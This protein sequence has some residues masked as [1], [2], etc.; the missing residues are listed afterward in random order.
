MLAPVGPPAV[1]PDAS[2]ELERLGEAHLLAGVREG[3]GVVGPLVVPARTACLHCQHL[4]RQAANPVWPL[5]AMQLVRPRDAGHDPCDV[6]LAS[7]VAALAVMQALD[8]LDHAGGPTGEPRATPGPRRSEEPDT[9]RMDTRSETEIY[10]TQSPVSSVL[11]ATA[12]GTLELAS[13]GWRIRRRSWPVHPN[14]P[15]RSARTAARRASPDP[16]ARPG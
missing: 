6:T 15:C 11:P 3:T 7:M 13:P 5:L 1:A 8:Y 16:G 9:R 2:L 4:Y 12:D 14:C 10:N